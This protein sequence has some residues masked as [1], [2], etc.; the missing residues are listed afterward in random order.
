MIKLEFLPPKQMQHNQQEGQ[1][2]F[3]QAHYK[4][5]CVCVCV[6]GPSPLYK[7]NIRHIHMGYFNPL[8]F[9]V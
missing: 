2:D 1:R 9:H 3:Y 5:T 4:P 7:V 8:L 6:C